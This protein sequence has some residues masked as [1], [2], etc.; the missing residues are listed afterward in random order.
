MVMAASL[1][2]SLH[3]LAAFTVAARTPLSLA[4]SRWAGVDPL[5]RPG[6]GARDRNE[7]ARRT[8]KN[9]TGIPCPVFCCASRAAAPRFIGE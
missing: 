3:H 2:A 7:L 4:G 6:D 5:R 8:K 9:G 1:M